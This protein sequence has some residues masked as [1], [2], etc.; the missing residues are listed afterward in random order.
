MARLR[1]FKCYRKL[2]RPYT[3]HSKYRELNYVRNRPHSRIVIFDSGDPKKPYNA[4]LSLVSK[5]ALQIRSNSLEST[6]MTCNRNLEK[7][8]G[9]NNYHMK[10]RVFPHH[11]LRENPLASGAGADRLSTGMAHSFGKSIGVA[12]QVKEGQRVITVRCFKENLPGVRAALKSC[13][14][15]LPCQCRVLET[16]ELTA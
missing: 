10:M 4:E 16:K 7:N 14:Y 2:E 11:I 12:A 8:C 1:K 13:A 15:K 9:Q 3:R 5:E 6:R